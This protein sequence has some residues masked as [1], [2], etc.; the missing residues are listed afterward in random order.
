MC[1]II[2][3]LDKRGAPVRPETIEPAVAALHHRG[4]DDHATFFFENAALGFARL[5]IVDVPHGQQPLYNEDRDVVAICN[6]EIYNYRA[7]RS[8]LIDKGHRFRSNSDCEVLLHLYEEEGERLV[9][10]LDGMFGFALIDTR[11]KRAIVA[12]DRLGIKPLLVHDGPEYL[13]IASEAKA[14]LATGLVPFRLDGQAV[15]DFFAFAYIPGE[16]TA[17]QGIENLP[18]ATVMT[19]DLGRGGAASSR[20][21]WQPEFPPFEG[22]R[23]HSIG[24]SAEALRKTLTGAISSHRI[25]DLPVGAYLSGGMDSTVTTMLLQQLM[26]TDGALQTFSIKFPGSELDESAVFERTIATCGF[27]SQV[28]D[29]PAVDAAQ[30]QRVL[31]HLEQ[32]QT[33]LLDAPMFALSRLVRD[34]GFKVVLSGEGSDELFGGYFVYTLNQIRRALA[35]PAVARFRPLLL[36]RALRYYIAGEADRRKLGEILSADPSPVVGR[37]GTYPAWYPTWV[38]KAQQREGLFEG[39]FADSLGDGSA[40]ANLCRPLKDRYAGID[41]FNKSIYVELRSRLPNYIL[42]RADRNSMAHS[43][44]LRVPFLANQMIDFV[45]ALPPMMKMFALKEKY[46]LRKAFAGLLPRHVRKR[47][48]FGYDAPVAPFWEAKDELRDEMMSPA[49]LKRSGLFREQTVAGWARE[50]AA[51]AD[52]HRKTDLY[53]LL[54]SVLSVQLLHGAFAGAP[55]RT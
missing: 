18:P 48:K 41:E 33:S 51:T 24:P 4:P 9:E 17:F 26:G 36:G 44:E 19:I 7:L 39:N 47:T 21:Y 31:Y 30:F 22:N 1:G 52:P 32:P 13:V 28:L 43:V 29:A 8:E 3:V 20:E 40:M 55:G 50:A 25:G 38:M 16:R 6:G 5:S 35:M 45:C 15:Y 53:R 34:S 2:L 27:R 37:F 11:Q 49:A 46:V 12:R 14:I 54:T 23:L 42:N 10:R